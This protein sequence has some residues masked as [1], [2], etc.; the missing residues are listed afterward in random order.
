MKNL[1]L[2]SGLLL[3]SM[4]VSAQT[5]EENNKK[6]FRYSNKLTLGTDLA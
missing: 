6:Q 4:F 5:S 3:L 1:V 2:V